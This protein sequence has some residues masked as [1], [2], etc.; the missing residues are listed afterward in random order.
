MRTNEQT[1]RILRQ[2]QTSARNDAVVDISDVNRLSI[3]AHQRDHQSNPGRELISTGNI[4]LTGQGVNGHAAELRSVGLVM[5]RFQSLVDAAGASI[6]GNKSV[7]GRISESIVAKTQLL[8]SASPRPGSL[9]LDFHPAVRPEDELSDGGNV[10]L[11]DESD[12]LVD[13]SMKLVFDALGRA[14]KDEVVQDELA[15]MLIDAGPRFA[16]A[17]QRL[18]AAF[19]KAEFD[20]DFR[21]AKPHEPTLRVSATEGNFSRIVSLIQSR[22]LSVEEVNL[23]GAITAISVDRGLRLEVEDADGKSEIRVARGD[24]GREVI[25]SL[26]TSMVVRVR[27]SM[28]LEEQPG[29]AQKESFKAVSLEIVA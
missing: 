6:L 8:L 29:G 7:R 19:A 20:A 15:S 22:S 4:H 21:W 24:L 1:A 16:N 25:D 3:E 17:L 27:A 11:F 13:S 28:H 2:I 14:V 12:Q 26:N 18:S 23:V 5:E 9:N 10:S